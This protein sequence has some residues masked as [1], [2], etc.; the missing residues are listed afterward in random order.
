MS[1]RCY[2]LDVNVLVARVFEDHI[3]HR[4]AKTWL[5]TP[6]L[7]WATCPFTEAGFLRY[8]TRPGKNSIDMGQATAILEELTQ[9]PGYRYLSISADWQTLTRPFFKRLHGHNQITD[10]WL[11]GIAIQEGLILATFDRAIPHMA[12]E[13]R[14]NVFLLENQ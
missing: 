11:L 12:A 14:E 6:N 9:Q 1:D 4:A 13:H 5:S 2:L 8:A 3:H 7:E 10:A